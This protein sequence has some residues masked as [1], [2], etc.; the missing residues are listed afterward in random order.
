[1]AYRDMFRP[2]VSRESLVLPELG[3]LGERD[4]LAVPGNHAGTRP[5]A[6]PSI[7]QTNHC[8]IGDPRVRPQRILQIGGSD[9]DAAAADDILAATDEC[10]VPIGIHETN[11][12]G[13]EI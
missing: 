7:R 4:I 6:E 2:Q 9:G 1:M 3:D 10:Q 12:T 8:N 11:V 13:L 5:F